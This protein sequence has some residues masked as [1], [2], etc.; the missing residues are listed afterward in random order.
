[1]EIEGVIRA[2]VSQELFL[3]PDVFPGGGAHRL[4]RP[5]PRLVVGKAQGLGA[6]GH[7]RQLPSPLPAHGPATVGRGVAKPVIGDRLPI[8]GRQQIVPRGIAVGIADRLRVG[9]HTVYVVIFSFRQDISAQVVGILPGLPC[10]RVL[11]PYQLVQTVVLILRGMGAVRIRQQ[12]SVGV[13]GIAV[14]QGRVPVAAALAADLRR[15]VLRAH[16]PVAVGR[17]EHRGTAMLHRLPGHAAVAV[18]GDALGDVAVADAHRPVVIIVGIRPGLRPQRTA[19]IDPG[20]H[21]RDVLVPVIGPGHVGDQVAAAVHYH[22][23]VQP[24]H[25]VKAVM[26]RRQQGLPRDLPAGE[27]Q[28]FLLYPGDLT[29]GI[30]G[31]IIPDPRRVG[32]IGVPPQQIVRRRVVAV[33]PVV[34]VAVEL[35]RQRPGP[36]VV[37]VADQGPG[38]PD[39]HRRGEIGRTVLKAVGGGVRGRVAVAHTGEQVVRIG[40]GDRPAVGARAEGIFRLIKMES[41]FYQNSNSSIR[42]QIICLV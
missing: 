26:L 4:L 22:D 35:L 2:N 27:G 9:D 34:P 5:Q 10:R 8:V 31:I 12:I 38:A 14:A 1:M 42:S 11:L 21:G 37:A 29:P 25:G 13:V 24:V 15:G 19:F 39:L 41:R 40:I 30:V 16:V 32:R 23:P 28:Q 33:A 18:V 36:A 3:V 7:P 17:A 20:G 6:V